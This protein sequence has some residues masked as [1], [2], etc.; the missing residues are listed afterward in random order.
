M[1]RGYKTGGRKPGS[2]NRRTLDVDALTANVEAVL[3]EPFQGDAHALLM[4][5]YKDTTRDIEL[6]I[7]AA[8]AAI[9]F[10]KPTLGV[11]E[12]GPDAVKN[13][14]ARMPARTADMNEWERRYVPSPTTPLQ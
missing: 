9:R 7:D 5:I 14:V 12:T 1:A 13:Y 6:R 10:E 8:K 4:L 2:R 3:A 11:V